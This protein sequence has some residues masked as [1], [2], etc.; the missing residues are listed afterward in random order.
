MKLKRVVI[1][2][3]G[4]VGINAAKKLGREKNLEVTLIDRRNYHLFQPLLYQVATA[5]LSP[6]EI[7]VPI[8]SLLSLYKNTKVV[9]DEIDTVDLEK[10][11]VHG[12]ENSYPFDYLILAAGGTHNYFGNEKWEADAPGLKTI[13]QATEIRRRIMTAFE[14]AE[15]TEDTIERRRQLTFVVVGGG[16]TG[17]ELAGAIGEMTRFTLAKDFR[18]IDPK[19][20][21]IIL[22]EAGNRILP[23]FDKDLSSKATRDLESIGVQVWTKS[24]VTNIN[25][26]CVKINGENISA[27]TVIWAAGIKA[28][29]ISGNFQVDK[30][31]QGRIK[32]FP[33]LTLPKYPNV[34]VAGDLAHCKGVNGDPLPSI[35][36]VA[37]Q[38]GRY[39][40]KSILNRIN[41][42]STE[43]FN[44]MDKGQMAT[45]GRKKAIVQSFGF[46][47]GGFIAWLAWLFIHI[48]YLS[49]FK[50]RILVLIQWAY[51][52][53]SFARGARL[54][55]DRNWR[56]FDED[57][58]K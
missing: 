41:S 8:R 20:T 22:A 37:I 12:K 42:K 30:D 11:Y 31:A 44:Y 35:A 57:K 23:S 2:G 26:N 36:P 32:V 15:I 49:G 50:N 56:L 47:F 17:V 10:K 18:S 4:F 43:D 29:K 5:G 16:P 39:I 55:V 19:L 9:L 24:P 51:S 40:A 54:I 14:K 53:F 3:G 7:A 28:A 46:K 21:R 45:I 33:D 38:Q 48:L 13:A 25:S 6:A 52:Y 34:F 58:K 1:V 27:A